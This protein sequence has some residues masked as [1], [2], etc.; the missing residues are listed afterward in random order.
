MLK[1]VK[2]CPK[3]GSSVSLYM[4]SETGMQYQCSNCGYIGPLVLESDRFLHIH[5]VT[6]AKKDEVVGG[7]PFLV[8]VKAPAEKGK[9]NKAV[10]R[11]LS[12]YFGEKVQIKSGFKS[13]DKV[14]ELE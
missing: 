4:G 8:R 7:E 11:L 12:K 2:R 3:C 13:R 5:V 6:R 9:A 14:V 10:V 1:T